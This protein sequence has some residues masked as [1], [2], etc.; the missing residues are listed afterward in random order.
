MADPILGYG[1]TLQVDRGS[2]YTTIV[3]M[4]EIG[5]FGGE[6][7]DVDV[8]THDS[9]A[10]N[11]FRSFIRGLQ[12]PGEVSLTGLWVGDPTVTA[13][14]SDS[15]AGA[16]VDSILPYRIVLP[17]GMGTFASEGYMKTFKINPQLDGR[18]EWSG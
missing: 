7:E 1:S 18:L 11:G 16:F 14:M 4:V 10:N 2:G 6:G 17:S 12:D 13:L 9:T 15:L 8:T 5:E 3:R